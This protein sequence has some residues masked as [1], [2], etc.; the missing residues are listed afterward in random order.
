MPIADVVGLTRSTGASGPET[1]LG[2]VIG[3][4]AIAEGG[5]KRSNDRKT[6]TDPG[7]RKPS[8]PINS[9]N[10][11]HEHLTTRPIGI[12]VD[13]AF[14]FK[15]TAGT[16]GLG[17][18]GRRLINQGPMTIPVDPARADVNQSLRDAAEGFE[19]M[20]HPGVLVARGWRWSQ[21]V[22]RL[23][24]LWKRERGG[25]VIEIPKVG[26][27]AISLKRFS[28]KERARKLRDRDAFGAKSSSK[29]S[30]D[31]AAAHDKDGE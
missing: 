11:E 30:S 10:P 19:G 26:R 14:G 12:V 5:F 17:F 3:M 22:E 16:V 29:A 27:D 1:G 8:I 21:V 15:A 4:D 6:L 7:F 31:V 18:Q 25:G 9:R 28:A 24:A 13:Q 20:Q 2:Q 23:Y